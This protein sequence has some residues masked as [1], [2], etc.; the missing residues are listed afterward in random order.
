M[1][2]NTFSST[3][4]TLRKKQGV[5]QEQLANHL[6]VSPQAVSK[7]ENG[8]YPEGDLLPKISDFF[9]VSISY[10]Y[11]QE[12]ENVSLEQT[13]L[14]ELRDVIEKHIL[15][16]KSG[17]DHS[18]YFDKMLDIVWAFQIGAWKNNKTYYN[19]PTPENDTRTAS[20][21]TDNAGFGYFN[22]NEDNQF[23][24]LAREPK[25][26]F[27]KTL[28]PTKELRE[29]FELLGTPGA[30]EI[31]SYMLSLNCNEYVSASTIAKQT[32]L[33]QE[34]TEG[35]LKKASAFQQ[36]SNPAFRCIQIKNEKGI[37]YAY[38]IDLSNISPYISLL[39]N[40]NVLINS[41]HG[42]SMQ[43]GGRGKSWF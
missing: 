19:R 42:Y 5:T 31:L 35:L 21:I 36:Q 11:G 8:S 15:E 6:G 10:L 17:C 7:W 27:A 22:L 23:F 28:K 32:G 14:N 26:G 39:M 40:A 16:G 3:L 38:G 29:F 4:Q 24:L 25:E 37:E 12:S 9:G 34:K 20:V 43:I 41:P 33:S 30:L 2:A 1:A 13:V 18:D